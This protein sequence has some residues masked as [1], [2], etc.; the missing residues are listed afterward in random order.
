[1]VVVHL[2]DPHAHEV[3]VTH[4]LDLRGQSIHVIV[5]RE[6]W[7]FEVEERGR[8]VHGFFPR[9]LHVLWGLGH[10]LVVKPRQGLVEPATDGGKLGDVG[11]H[12]QGYLEELP[13]LGDL[14]NH[15]IRMLVA[16]FWGLTSLPLCAKLL[17]LVSQGVGD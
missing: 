4:L 14:F 17:K 11:G 12:I 1:M 2:D 8:V 7:R 13:P 5:L 6:S 16:S 10:E 3:L 9:P 15:A